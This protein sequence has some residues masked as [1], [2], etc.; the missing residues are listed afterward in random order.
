MGRGPW[1]NASAKVD[2]LS[3]STLAF[4]HD[5]ACHPCTIRLCVC[6]K[7]QFLKLELAAACQAF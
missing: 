1:T 7:A 4:A 2:V 3:T 5:V 6:V